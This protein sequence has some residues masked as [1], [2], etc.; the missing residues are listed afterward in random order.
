MHLHYLKRYKRAMKGNVSQ[1]FLCR[2]KVKRD[3]CIGQVAVWISK[4]SKTL[5]S[6][7]IEIFSKPISFKMCLKIHVCRTIKAEILYNFIF[8]IFLCKVFNFLFIHW[9]TELF[10]S[11]FKFSVAFLYKESIIVINYFVNSLITFYS[12][13]DLWNFLKSQ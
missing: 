2:Q 10:Y 6:N 8:E 9:S 13:N 4:S 11:E 5:I 7:L 12:L 1:F 3:H